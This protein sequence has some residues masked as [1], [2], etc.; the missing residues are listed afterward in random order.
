MF[1]NDVR[2]KKLN[3][4]LLGKLGNNYILWST[5]HLDATRANFLTAHWHS[6]GCDGSCLVGGE[7]GCCW[8]KF[9]KGKVNAVVP[10]ENMCHN[11]CKNYP[12]LSILFLLRC[13]FVQYLA[14]EHT[15]KKFSNYISS[16]NRKP[17]IT[18]AGPSQ[19]SKSTLKFRG[20]WLDRNIVSI[21]WKLSVWIGQCHGM[22]LM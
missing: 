7:G 6:R 22:S 21:A 20:D 15:F 19:K 18:L 10:R 2:L 12:G 11:I 1:T 13:L 8:T 9:S 14:L 5:A 17:P 4:A 16:K 3:M